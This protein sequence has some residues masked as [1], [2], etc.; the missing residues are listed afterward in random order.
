MVS[1]TDWQWG[2]RSDV[3]NPKSV[4]FSVILVITEVV[5][6]RVMGGWSNR[7]YPLLPRTRRSGLAGAKIETQAAIPSNEIVQLVG[8]AKENVK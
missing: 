1:R 3:N 7:N 5:I 4:L 6:F 2:A 8:R